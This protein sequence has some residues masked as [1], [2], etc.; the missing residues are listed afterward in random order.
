MATINPNHFWT[1]GKESSK[2]DQTF[3]EQKTCFI[4]SRKIAAHWHCPLQTE[5]NYAY[6]QAKNQSDP[7]FLSWDIST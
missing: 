2:R 1:D 6:L 3:C 5:G 7:S 4:D